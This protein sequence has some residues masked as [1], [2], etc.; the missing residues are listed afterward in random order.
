MAAADNKYSK[1][2]RVIK[3]QGELEEVFEYLKEHYVKIK[4]V[5]Q[6]YSSM[7]NYPS[8]GWT[9][10]VDMCEECFMND[11]IL[12]RKQIDIVFKAVNFEIVQLEDNPDRDLCRYEFFEI[13]VRMA[14][15]KYSRMQLTPKE[16][17]DKLLNEHLYKFAGK[18][19]A[20]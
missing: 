1:I 2:G 6:Y 3:K 14:I 5:F 13:L 18:S 11:K 8:I 15:I 16:A 17:L 19:E 9:D 20:S 10:F 4:D 12:D 7:S